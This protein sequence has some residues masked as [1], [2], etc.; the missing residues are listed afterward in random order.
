MR[1]HLVFSGPKF[2]VEC[3]HRGEL[4]YPATWSTFSIADCLL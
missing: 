1:A 3:C 4:Y 2:F